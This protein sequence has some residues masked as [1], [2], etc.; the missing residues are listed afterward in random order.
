ME[1][2]RARADT[3][4]EHLTEEYFVGVWTVAIRGVEEGDAALDRAPVAGGL[5]RWWL[6][7]PVPIGGA[8]RAIEERESREGDRGR[9]RNGNTARVSQNVYVPAFQIWKSNPCFTKM[10]FMIT[11]GWIKYLQKCHCRMEGGDLCRGGDKS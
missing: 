4:T 8:M 11:L 7:A 9:V 2:T 10:P 6:V 5:S 1:G 3:H